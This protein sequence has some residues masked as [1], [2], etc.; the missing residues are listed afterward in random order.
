[1][2]KFNVLFWLKEPTKKSF[3]INASK[4]TLS[5]NQKSASNLHILL[6]TSL[7]V[8]LGITRQFR[9]ISA[10]IC[11]SK[12]KYFEIILSQNKMSPTQMTG[13]LAISAF[14]ITFSSDSI[15]VFLIENLSCTKYAQKWHRVCIRSCAE[16]LYD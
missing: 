9:S 8:C 1:M 11:H 7:I 2:W 4:M 3:Q 14:G 12:P 15:F 10:P 6:K 5:A 13:N 16:C